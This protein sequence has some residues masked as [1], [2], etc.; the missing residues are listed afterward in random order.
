MACA[1]VAAEQNVPRAET[2]R[3]TAGLLTSAPT[4]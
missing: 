4:R 1:G 2:A 3:R